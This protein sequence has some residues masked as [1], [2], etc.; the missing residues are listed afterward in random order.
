MKMKKLASAALAALMSV[1]TFASCG[2]GEDTA[3]TI[4]IGVSGPF[5]G[6]A[7]IYGTAVKNGAEIAVEEFIE[8]A[9]R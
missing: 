9:R 6:G 7:A 3:G 4:Q 5:T 8:Y 2:G 1:M